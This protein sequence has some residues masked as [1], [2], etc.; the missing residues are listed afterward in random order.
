[1]GFW[2][3]ENGLHLAN[4]VRGTH[5]KAIVQGS[6]LAVECINKAAQDIRSE[7]N[8]LEIWGGKLK[9]VVLRASEAQEVVGALFVKEELDMSNFVLPA[10]LKGIDIYYSNPKSPASVASKKLYSF[11]DITLADTILGKNITYDV[12]SFFQ[13]NIPVF[14]QTLK[15]IKKLVK[16]KNIVDMYSGVGT[17][18]I[19]VGATT[20]VE[21]DNNNIAMAQKNAGKAVKVVHATS[22]TALEYITPDA[23]MIVDPP[24]AGL[25]KSVI[26]K[27][28]EVRPL[29][30]VYLSCNPSTQARDIKLLEEHYKIIYAQ[31]FNFFPRTPH[32]ESLIVLELK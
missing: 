24:R 30:I 27:I 26:D 2:G 29:Q 13:V 31:G 19:T 11:G 12:L 20:L 32:I 15:T 22:E 4:Y 25:H 21:S 1:M 23:T 16:S 6:A 28:A 14:E 18:G 9:T 5:G 7:L 8:K 17:I 3:D 10:S